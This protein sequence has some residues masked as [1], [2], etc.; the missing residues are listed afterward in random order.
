MYG[1]VGEKNRIVDSSKWSRVFAFDGIILLVVD[2]F[3]SGLVYY[4]KIDL[5]KYNEL[6]D[7]YNLIGYRM[8][9]KIR[10]VMILAK[11]S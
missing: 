4:Q 10:D 7:G 6:F 9:K 1:K 5:H 2:R 11:L 8:E 3:R